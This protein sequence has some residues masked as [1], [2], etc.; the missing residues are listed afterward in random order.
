MI[1][2]LGYGNVKKHLKNDPAIASLI[3]YLIPSLD[4]TLCLKSSA[5]NKDKPLISVNLIVTT[6]TI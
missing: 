5:P 4:V 1:L 2:N 3:E 6:G